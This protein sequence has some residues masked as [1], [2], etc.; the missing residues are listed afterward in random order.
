VA[1]NELIA[2]VAIALGDRPLSTCPLADMNGDQ[3]VAINELIADVNNA[4]N[5]C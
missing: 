3:Q 1:I 5:G 4:L 2:A